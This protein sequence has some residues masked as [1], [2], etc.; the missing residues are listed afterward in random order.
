MFLCYMHLGVGHP[1]ALQKIARDCLDYY[2][3][4]PPQAVE[5]MDTNEGANNDEGPKEYNNEQQVDGLGNESEDECDELDSEGGGD[6]EESDEEFGDLGELRKS[7]R[8]SLM[9]SISKT[10]CPVAYITSLVYS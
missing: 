6:I 9:T 2:K 5:A 1:V 8:K 4:T 3:S 7:K 10:G